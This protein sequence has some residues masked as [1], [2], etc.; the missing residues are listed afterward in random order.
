MKKILYIIFGAIVI[1]TMLVN[2]SFEKTEVA[3][4]QN[5]LRLHVVANSDSDVD[6]SLKLKVRDRIIEETREVFDKETDINSA[7]QDIAA[8]LGKI[9]KCARDEIKKSGF[10]YDVNVSF[11]KS[12]FPT[13]N[14]GEIVLPAGSYDALE[15]KIGS[16]EGKNWWCVL[17][18]PLCFVDQTCVSCDAVLSVASEDTKSFISTDKAALPKLRFKTY[19]LWQSGKEKISVLFRQ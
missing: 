6:Q 2:Y 8:N 19:E 1:F 7:R 16:A 12:R 11:G 5:F 13:K 18:P 17:F 9:E 10:D 4:A 14:Y 3:L 15:V